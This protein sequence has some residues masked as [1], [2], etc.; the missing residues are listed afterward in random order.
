MNTIAVI[1]VVIF[2]AVSAFGQPEVRLVQA[3][4]HVADQW[5]AYPTRALSDLPA[6]ATGKV[7]SDLSQFGG[8]LAC[9][10]NATGFF[11][12]TN[13]FGRWWLVD[14]EGCLFLDKGVSSVEPLNGANAG[15][16]LQ[17]K[18]GGKKEWATETTTLLRSNGFNNLGAWSDTDT[19][20]QTPHPLAYTR[21]LN[22]MSS[23]GEQRGGVYQ[24]PGH[25]GYPKDCI[26]VFDPEFEVFC[27]TYARRLAQMKNDPWLLG[28]FSDNEMPLWRG[29]LRNYLK[30]P[31][32]N[33]GYQSA[34]KWLQAR[35]G[36]NATTNEITAQDEKDFLAFVVDRYYRIVSSAIKKYDP[37]H[38]YLG[39]RFNGRVLNEPEVFKAAGPYVDVVSVNYYDAWTPSQEKLA[40]WEAESGK[41]ILI[42][43]WYTKAEDSGLAN[44]G[45]AGWIVKTQGDRGLF[46]QNFTLAL[47]QSKVC[48][49]WDWFK[50]ADN[51]PTDT[52]ADPSNR[53]ANKGIV[54]ILYNP[55]QPLLEAMKQINDR[56][57]SLSAYFAGSTSQLSNNDSTR[58]DSARLNAN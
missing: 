46:Y 56:V 50:Y 24:Q 33:A 17:Q 44:T 41:P 39:S 1:I 45:G 22:F 19:L 32:Q 55:Y 27:D 25:A 48:V 34:L 10:V 11:Y 36:E 5:K 14:P 37:N 9:K 20:R 13:T 47:L 54:N 51:D 35:H 30:L 12:P 4:V 26:F 2:G 21:V 52:K 42:T 31:A 58:N 15:E 6:M 43:E 3:K 23:Y 49:G 8:L 29:A 18:F 7:D 57:Y 40:S 16:I 38:L 53:D 28:Y